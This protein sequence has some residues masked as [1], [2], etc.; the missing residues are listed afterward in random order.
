MSLA[1]ETDDHRTLLDRLR[2][3]LDLEDATLRREGDRIVV[4]VVPEH[5]EGGRCGVETGWSILWSRRAA[6]WY[7][8]LHHRVCVGGRQ[9]DREQREV[10]AGMVLSIVETGT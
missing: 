5:G 2:C 7:C 6:S 4:V 8:L 10:E 1:D 9:E 3:V